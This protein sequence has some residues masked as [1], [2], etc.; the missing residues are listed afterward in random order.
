MPLAVVIASVLATEVTVAAAAAIITAT[1]AWLQ[2]RS[3]GLALRAALDVVM[4]MPPDAHGISGPASAQVAR[5]NLLRRAQFAVMATRRITADIIAARSHGIPLTQAL[6]ESVTRERR[7]FGQHMTA[8]WQR[9]Q[10]AAMADTAAS[11]YGLLLGWHTVLD[12]HTSAEC[13]AAN[14][15]NFNV[16]SMPSIGFPGGVHPH[17]RCYPGRP[18]PGG[19]ML[20]SG[21]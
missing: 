7:F 5:L 4:G 2:A 16:T 21:R 11:T 6:A 17:C 8:I 9:R 3:E 12:K 19:R 15:R 10:A 1:P 13:R 20:P 18:W 14:G